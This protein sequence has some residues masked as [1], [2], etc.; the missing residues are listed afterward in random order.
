[1][2]EV[3]GKLLNCIWNMCSNKIWVREKFDVGVR[4]DV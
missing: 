2:N 3:G 4:Q 1:M